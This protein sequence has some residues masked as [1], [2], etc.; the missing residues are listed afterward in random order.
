MYAREAIFSVTCSALLPI[1][2]GH[3][4]GQDYPSKPVRIVTGIAGGSQDLAARIIAQD[5]AGSLGQP[6][7]IDNRPATVIPGQ[8]V[9]GAPPD[10][11]TL[12]VSGATL[13]IG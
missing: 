13:W 1:V 3:A 10:G 11:Y 5:L 6:V 7:V 8:I 9:S 12:L 4:V 2:A